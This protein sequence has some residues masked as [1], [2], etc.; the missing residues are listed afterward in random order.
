M[1]NNIIWLCLC[2]AQLTFANSVK[3]SLYFKNQF[4]QMMFL[5]EDCDACGCSASGGGMGFSSMLNT[6]FV[7]LRYMYQSYTTKEGVF[8]DSP[9]TDENFNTLQIWARIPITGKIQITAL[10]PY[11]SNN[12]ELITGAESIKGIGDMTVMGMYVVHETNV[13]STTAYSHKLQMGA[14]IKAPTGTY[15]SA[16]NGTLNPSFQLGTGSWDC[17][18]V[19]EYVM[20]KNELGMNATLSYAL[21]TENEK[22]YKFGNQINYGSVLFYLLDFDSVKLVPQAGIAGEIYDSNQQFKQEVIGTK[23][24]ILFGKLGFE[25][26]KDRFSFGANAMFPI[27]QNLTG[28]NVEANYRWSI[29]LNY[30]L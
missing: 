8:K 13:D 6:N 28:G 10:L 27:N 26:G 12:R 18:L 3:D 23:G 22:H 1:K 4:R 21:K 9:W 2:I 11:H 15:N 7:G 20:K 5:E 17:L 29:N 16:N 30:G 25:I 24:D 19:T 14:G